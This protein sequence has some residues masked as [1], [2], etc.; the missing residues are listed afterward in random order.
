MRKVLLVA[1]AVGCASGQ[2]ATSARPADGAAALR[3]S[4][5]I[6]SAAP[7][8]V[9]QAVSGPANQ[10]Y[11]PTRRAEV[12][13]TLH[14]IRIADP[15]RW[16]EDEKSSEVQ[17]WMAAQDGF[18]RAQLRALPGRDAIARRLSE[19]LYVDVLGAPRHRGNRYFFARQF[20]TKE[21][22]VVFVK[23][24]R[25]GRE[26]VLLDPNAWT[27][28]GSDALGGWWPSWDGKR[29]AFTVRHNNSDES[30]MYLLDVA[31]GK[32][33]QA[34]VIEGAKYASAS[35]TPEGDG[36]YYT[37]LPVDERIPVAER[38]GWQ[39]IKFHRVGEDPRKDR[40]VVEKLG[41]PTTFQSAEVSKD[42][43]WLVRSVAHGWGRNDLYFRDARKAGAPWTPLAAGK[44]ALYDVI[45]F[46]DRF[47]LTTNEGAPHS[48]IFAVDPS[49]PAREDWK[50]I[51]P[52]R[53]D[54]T[55]DSTRLVGGK[56]A[57][58]YLKDAVTHL[59][60]HDLD[61][62]V[63]R[64]I[65]LPEVGTAGNLVGRE[66]EDEA[67]FDFKSYTHPP[68]IFRTSVSRGKIELYSRVKLP[69]DPSLY[70]TEQIFATSKDGTRVPVFVVR[71][72]GAP[73]DG[74]A[75]TLLYGYGGFNVAI[76]PAFK[77]SI[78][79]WL[80]R[81][82]IYAEAVLRGGS[83]YGEDW[84]R[85]GM[86]GNK[87]HVF[88]DFI[89][90]AEE[91][92][93]QGYTRPSR[94][95]IRGGSNGGL[96]VGAA[97]TQRPELFAVVLCHVPL[98]DMLRYHLYGSGKTWIPEY[99]TADDPDQ[100]KFLAAYSPQQR[101]GEGVKYPATLVLSADA[102]DRVDPMHAR[103]FAAALQHSSAGGPVLLRIEKHS[104]HGG[105]DLVRATIE[106][107]A[108]EYAF[109]FSQFDLAERPAAT[110]TR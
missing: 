106:K 1:F 97:E 70:E 92:L 65:R 50:E 13:D 19:L 4:S 32:R 93:R 86:L 60:V 35:W 89:A 11:P 29:L 68:E 15:Y 103:K 95:A 84:H 26:R 46:R 27:A 49:R 52:E 83:E 18:A 17:A 28:D 78:Y 72:K 85:A 24:G 3:P 39:T 90:A 77:G 55:L 82:G 96:L 45:A 6:P 47:Y 73:R 53:K 42:G 79:P 25:A 5:A 63:V 69:V 38:P 7:P 44:D 62:K 2:S 16:L 87:Q 107:T 61:G 36:F 91:L 104:G 108:D 21:K 99:G 110:A 41:D 40:V 94:L 14:G 67:Y 37:W 57:L 88:D 20:A 81:G 66:D 71:R 105:A 58:V 33:S 31:T 101:I 76:T 98:I 59:E 80:E 48:R 34:D 12:A 64:E 23:E 75:P 8:P 9:L 100:F 54:A 109:A 102:D 56:L 51:V 74:K 22:A 43:R 10:Q 30:V